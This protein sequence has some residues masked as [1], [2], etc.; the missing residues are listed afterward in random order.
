MINYD[1]FKNIQVGD[2]IQIVNKWNRWSNANSGGRMDYLLGKTFPVSTEAT[3]ESVARWGNYSLRIKDSRAMYSYWNLNSFC[4]EK[5]I[6]NQNIKP[7]TDTSLERM[8][9]YKYIK[10]RKNDK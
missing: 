2:Y 7:I 6:K 9:Q 10:E 3:A 4:I 8:L 5:V 1:K